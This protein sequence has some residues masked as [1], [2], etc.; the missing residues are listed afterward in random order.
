MALFFT[1]MIT[2]IFFPID[3]VYGLNKV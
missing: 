1:V 3:F 2:C